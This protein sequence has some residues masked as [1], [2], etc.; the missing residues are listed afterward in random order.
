MSDA[1]T[2][3]VLNRLLGIH[4]A[5]FLMYITYARPYMRN[6]DESTAESLAQM[7]ADQQTLSGR[8]STAISDA[9]G[10]IGGGAFPMEFTSQHDLAIEYLLHRAVEYQRGDIAAI[11]SCVADLALAPAAKA[12][13]DEALGLAK[14]HLESLEELVAPAQR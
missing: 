7:V 4:Q 12:L 2:I 1:S 14:G 5:S 13:A 9:G 8:I 11:E 10:Q 6:G 3:D